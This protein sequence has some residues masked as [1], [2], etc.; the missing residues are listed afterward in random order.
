MY[1]P[2]GRRASDIARD[3]E[4]AVADGRL[5]SGAVLPSVRVLATDL[6]VAPGTIAAAYRLLARAGVVEA[7]PGRGTIVRA[8]RSARSRRPPLVPPGTRDLATGNPDPACLPDVLAVLAALVMDRIEEARYAEA[9]EE[10]D[11]PPSLARLYGE[12]PVL[13]ELAVWAQAAFEAD[14]IG[15]GAVT[16]MGGALDAVERALQARVRPG[17]R[18]GVE[19]PGYA[20]VLDLVAALGLVAE[21]MRLDEEGVLPAAL[22]AALERGLDA[23]VLTPRAQNPTGAAFTADRAGELRQILAAHDEVLVIEDDHAGPI[24]GCPAF[25]VTRPDGGP[26]MVVRSCSKA[27]GP[28]LRVAVAAGD[29]ATITQM[30]A[31]QAVGTGWVSRILQEI[32]LYLLKDPQTPELLAEVVAV[33]AERRAAL[34]AALAGRSIEATGRSG[35][36]IWVPVAEEGPVVAGM[37]ARKWAITAGDRFRIT[38]PPAVRITVAALDPVDAPVVAAAMR[39]S[40]GREGREEGTRAG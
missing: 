2:S 31:R 23:V 26:F 34:L 39:S 20:G 36:N 13:P 38:S 6:G 22:A 33:Y 10:V 8:G 27:F 32:A 28:D 12:P 19:D 5:A 3:V 17:G 25:T 7:N 35:L 14:G 9:D 21:P 29:T 18:V 11:E 4:A 16:V 37:A 30:Q 40:L 24:A 1:R 15:P